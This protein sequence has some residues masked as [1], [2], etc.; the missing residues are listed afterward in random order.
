MMYL[1]LDQGSFVT[2]SI[3]F[4]IPES[5]I[6]SLTAPFLFTVLHKIWFRGDKDI[7]EARA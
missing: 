4:F 5:L 7:E 6:I 2:E 3:K 1:K